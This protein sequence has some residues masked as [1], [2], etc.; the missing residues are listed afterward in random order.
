MCL[1]LTGQGLLYFQQRLG[2]ADED[3]KQDERFLEL[4]RKWNSR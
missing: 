2:D 1:S 4:N 3:I